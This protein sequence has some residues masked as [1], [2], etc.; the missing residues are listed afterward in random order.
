MLLKRSKIVTFIGIWLIIFAIDNLLSFLSKSTFLFKLESMI[1]YRILELIHGDRFLA[2]D[3]VLRHLLDVVITQNKVIL[4][5]YFSTN[6][7]IGILSLFAGIGLL[8][9]REWARR[10]GLL[11]SIIGIFE[12]LL[13]RIFLLYKFLERLSNVLSSGPADIIGGPYGLRPPYFSY[14]DINFVTIFVIIIHLLFYIFLLW[15]LN[16]S[17]VKEQFKSKIQGQFQ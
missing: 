11:F 1:S 10:L 3:T 7:I 8:R 9:L 14:S 16:L 5:S 6:Y 13:S 2:G 12:A 17:S 15:F 4:I